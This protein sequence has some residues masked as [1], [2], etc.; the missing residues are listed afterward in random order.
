MPDQVASRRATRHRLAAWIHLAN[1]R[2]TALE[3]AD[4]RMTAA[5]L[6]TRYRVNLYRQGL[7][8]EWEAAADSLPGTLTYGHL[9]DAQ[10]ATYLL[11]VVLA[12][13]EK[14]RSLL[15]TDVIPEYP[16]R[17]DVRLWRNVLEHWEDDAG[18]SLKK[19]MSS[20]PGFDSS[21][22]YYGGSQAAIGH[23]STDQVRTWL[24]RILAAIE[25][26]SVRDAQVVPRADSPVY[27]D[28]PGRDSGTSQ[29]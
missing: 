5:G 11:V 21:T 14:A 18:P 15:P 1:D 28:E 23:L 29:R 10:N 22:L 20:E 4:Q 16:D 9:W 7:H 25:E 27:A 19:L 13:I 24:G 26:A 2:L 12:Q 3:D 17:R 8:E 6:A